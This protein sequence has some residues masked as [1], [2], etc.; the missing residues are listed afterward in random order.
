MIK[1]NPTPF[2]VICEN[3]NKKDFEKHDVM[4]YLISCYKETE[5]KD[6]PTTLDEFKDFVDRK[7]MYMYW[8][9]CQYEIVLVDWPCQRN[10]KKIDIYWQIKNNFDLVVRLFMENVGVK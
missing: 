7:S 3:V 10:S 5:K 9:R 6:R 1:R 2:Y 4:P 8:A